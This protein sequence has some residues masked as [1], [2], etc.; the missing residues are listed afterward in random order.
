LLG[1][2]P[3]EVVLGPS[4][5]ALVQLL[6]HSLRPSW[7]EGDEVVV[8]NVD[9][10]TNVGPWRALEASGIV[11][12]EWRMRL[13]TCAL[14]PED[15]E[16]L[17]NDR[18]RLVA[19]SHCSNIVGTV[20]DVAHIASRVR[21][22]GA[23]SCVDGVA[24]APH[25]RVD[26]K[27]LGVDFYFAS[28]YKVYGPHMAALFGRRKALLAC[29]SANHFFVPEDAVALK[30]EP[31][32]VNYELTASLAG[33]LEYFVE[34]GEQLGLGP[35]LD[36]A[37]CFERIGEHESELVRPLLAFL[38]QHPRTR[39]IGS[40]TPDAN[41]RVPTVSFVAG[42]R[43]SSDVTAQLD[44]RQLATRFGH[45]YAYRLVRDL[46]LLEQDGV[47][48]ISLAHYN[49]ADEVER[50]IEALDEVL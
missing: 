40:P 29:R 41:H 38:E 6:A 4:S 50:L 42:D 27:A 45:F 49:T 5:T 19:F 13:E 43:L 28:L 34:L 32:N 14:H 48:R 2:G 22:G 30:L 7:R 47:V 10:E 1:A 44:R 37:G 8:T 15:L 12:R 17:L 23:L 18:T 9:H 33:I 21:A 16:P 46:G 20:H 25:R 11:V 3:E 26:V 24:F 36:L 31:G 39:I 35:S